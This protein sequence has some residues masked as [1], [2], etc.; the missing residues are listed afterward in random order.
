MQIQS[1]MILI[2]AAVGGFSMMSSGK[3]LLILAGAIIGSIVVPLGLPYLSD[4]KRGG[5]DNAC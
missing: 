1:E 4:V 3:P 2:G 5:G